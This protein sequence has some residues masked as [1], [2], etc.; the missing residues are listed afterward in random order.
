MARYRV[1]LDVEELEAEPQPEPEARVFQVDTNTATIDGRVAPYNQIEPGDVIELQA[2]LRRPLEI[3]NLTGTVEKPIIIRNPVD[4]IVEI[5][6]AYGWYG[7]WLRNCHYFRFAGIGNPEVEYGI[8]ITRSLNNG[9]IFQNKTDNFEIDHI[10]MKRVD[11][12]IG[13]QGQT[14]STVEADYD[15]DGDGVMGEN[16]VVT[17]DNY[18]QENWHIHHLKLDFDDSLVTQLGLYVGNSNYLEGDPLY[19]PVV[20][21]CHIHDIYIRNTYNKAFQVGSVTEGF[22]VHDLDIKECVMGSSV[23]N[24]IAISI[25]PGCNGEIHDCKVSDCN[26]GGL[27]WLGTGGKIHNNKIIRCGRPSTYFDH[28][29]YL[30]YKSNYTHSEKTEVYNNTIVDSPD[31]AII[32]GS[33]L[34][35]I[36]EIKNNIIVSKTAKYK[37]LASGTVYEN[38]IEVT[39]INN[40]DNLNYSFGS[41]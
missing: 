33:L 7:F 3:K 34:K 37:Q 31:Y 10:D 2:G 5:D 15:Y 32:V 36:R 41:N 28:G 26:G 25:N 1:T 35:G 20:H 17:R 24:P 4:G 29:I 30:S 14:I 39:A 27:W 16:D 19:N 12:G 18:V 23:S 21:N 38:N 40:P 9:I 8:K 13:I 22:D 6:S 11:N